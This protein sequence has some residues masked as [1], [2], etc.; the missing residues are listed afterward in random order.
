MWL[1]NP[2]I[3]KGNSRKLNS[4]WVGPYKVVKC[5]S[6]TVYRIQDTQTPRKRIV[7][8]FDRL[9]SCN[10]RM[11]TQVDARERDSQ[12]STD[13]N[14]SAQVQQATRQ[15][16]PGTNLQVRDDY[17]GEDDSGSSPTTARLQQ[18]I[19]SG[20]IHTGAVAEDRQD[21]GMTYMGHVL[22]E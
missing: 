10:E 7:V 3:P 9:K 22:T 6:D 12:E 1:C 17:E 11:R 20:D 14:P 4:P 21:T 2:V 13:I 15:L 8:H 19:N 16:P 18:I 5:I